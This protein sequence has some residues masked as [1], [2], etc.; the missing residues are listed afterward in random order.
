[1]ARDTVAVSDSSENRA[2]RLPACGV[3]F[4]HSYQ[5]AWTW[6]VH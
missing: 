2:T 5:W 6:L 3:H 1:L 4:I